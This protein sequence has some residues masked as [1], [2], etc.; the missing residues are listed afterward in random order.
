MTKRNVLLGCAVIM[1]CITGF[2]LIFPLDSQVTIITYN[3]RAE[4]FDGKV[5]KNARIVISGINNLPSCELDEAMFKIKSNLG[6]VKL[7]V[8][9]SFL[10]LISLVRN[11]DK[12]KEIIK[13][14]A[15]D[16]ARTNTKTP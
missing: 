1:L 6:W 4:S 11:P 2:I 13:A 8:F 14:A 7:L 10:I 9:M 15:E 3:T 16:T 5:L 12:P